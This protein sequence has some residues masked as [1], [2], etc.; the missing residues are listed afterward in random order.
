MKKG[1]HTS[2]SEFYQKN[3]PYVLN[4]AMELKNSENERG[5]GMSDRF[6]I[7]EILYKLPEIK[8]IKPMKISVAAAIYRY[9]G[10]R[11][12]F[13]PNVEFSSRMIGAAIAEANVYHALNPKGFQFPK[14]VTTFLN[15]PNF[16]VNDAGNEVDVTVP[17][18]VQEN[19]Y[20]TVFTNFSFYEDDEIN[21]KKYTDQN[22]WLKKY[23]YPFVD[24]CEK[25]LAKGGYLLLYFP[26]NKYTIYM[27][28]VHDYCVQNKR[29]HYLGVIGVTKED[30][31][32]ASAIF[33][34]RK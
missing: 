28:P 17:N 32:Y 10:S 20:D 27:K 18:V 3:Y 29:L 19:A 23:A 15:R 2:I 6:Y 24:T 8:R 26:D 5:S 21:K 34:W 25:A 22:D 1:K 9:F 11:V 12:I 33:V 14:D 4:K 16:Y 7:N 31:D 13:D 30:L